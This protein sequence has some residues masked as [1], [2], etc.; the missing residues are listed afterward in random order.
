MVQP[1]D[2]CD[3]HSRPRLLTAAASRQRRHRRTGIDL[4]AGAGRRAGPRIEITIAEDARAEATTGMVYVAI[5]RDNKRTPIEQAGPTG[6]PLFS[7]AVDGLQSGTAV[8]ITAAER[9]HPIA[10]LKDIPA[11]EYWMQPFVNVYTRFRPR[12]RQDRLAAHGPMGRPEL[13]AIAGQHLRRAGAGQFDPRSATPIRLIADKVIP[14]I[15]PPAD[16]ELVKRIKIESKILS[17]WWGHPDLSR[18][19]RAAAEGLRQASRACAIR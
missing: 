11:G 4:A 6:S 9:G 5:S 15:Q 1:G 16:T 18:R 12:R 14:P 2:D 3:A 17:K 13:E 19:D 8:A 10:S 7:V